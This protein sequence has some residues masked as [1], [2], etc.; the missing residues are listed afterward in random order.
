ML[1]DSEIIQSRRNGL[2]EKGR[3]ETLGGRISRLF[4]F[5]DMQDEENRG[6]KSARE[7]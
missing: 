4:K 2:N 6:G 7:A 1:K 5:L 3:L